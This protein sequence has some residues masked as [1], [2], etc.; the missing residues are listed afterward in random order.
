M[1]PPV[2]APAGTPAALAA[3]ARRRAF[4]VALAFL[5]VATHWP[6]LR[7]APS[8]SP[9]DKLA[10]AAGFGSL[11]ALC[12]LAFPRL[13][14]WAVLAGMLALGAV[15]E[16]TQA[17]PALQRSCD[18][19]DWL[20][21]ATGIVVA[22]ALRSSLAPVG[23]PAARLLMSRRCIASDLLLSRPM[24]WLHLMTA[25][26]LG[27]A[28]GAPVAVLID[29][30]F[31]RKGPQ[32]VQYGLIGAMLGAGV[33]VHAL[34]EAGVR[35][36]LR[37][38]ESG[39][40]CLAC[41]SA[42]VDAGGGACIAC[43]RAR[44]PSDWAP[45]APLAGEAELRACLIPVLVSV[46]TLVCLST[47]SIALVTS[48]RLRV[49]LVMRADTWYRTL[50]ADGRIL[51]DLSLIALLGAWALHRCRVRVARLVDRTGESCT[52]CGFD[53]RATGPGARTGSCPECSGGFVRLA[54]PPS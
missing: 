39:R 48:L 45:I 8:D 7:V 51:A 36:R 22:I 30:W 31:V 21:D 15:D 12:M 34:W 40:P 42:G 26:V 19:D 52:A 3:A 33:A 24:N 16:W 28:V 20:A 44:E 54:A 41:G 53:L 10:H 6:R 18:L 49:D 25:G 13:P 27:A 32:P 35:S 29:S 23:G 38:A 43:G 17:I 11:A 1:T 4:W 14:R 9:I 37:K 50:P 5:L 46:A 47:A 2:P